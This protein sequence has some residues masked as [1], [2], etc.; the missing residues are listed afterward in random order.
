MGAD[1]QS[2]RRTPWRILQTRLRR[3]PAIASVAPRLTFQAATAA[4][5]RSLV[6]LN[7]GG[8]VVRVTGRRCFY[9]HSVDICVEARQDVVRQART[10]YRESADNSDVRAADLSKRAR[11]QRAPAPAASCVQEQMV[12]TR[13]SVSPDATKTAGSERNPRAS[14]AS[15]EITRTGDLPRNSA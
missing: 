2:T 10:P 8:T 4:R 9:A 11:A 5:Q 15:A 13:S 12:K 7:A 6:S 14:G 1:V 3:D